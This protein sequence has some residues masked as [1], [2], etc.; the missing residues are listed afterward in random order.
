MKLKNILDQVAFAMK[1]LELSV[2]E[3]Q[4]RDRSDTRYADVQIKHLLVSTAQ[5][6]VL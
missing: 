6:F 1:M 5:V 3:F 2:L 4:I